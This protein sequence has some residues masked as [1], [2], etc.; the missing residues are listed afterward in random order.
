MQVCEGFV[1]TGEEMSVLDNGVSVVICCHNSAERL[2]DT[3]RHIAAQ[4]VSDGVAWEVIVVDNASTDNTKY[5]A[6]DHWAVNPIAPFQVV[7]EPIL[8][9]SHARATG[10][11]K[12][13][14]EYVSFIDD[15]NWVSSDWV[16]HVFEIVD[17]NTSVAALGGRSSVVT[18]G[19]LP[20]WFE[21]FA[22]NY[23]I[24]AQEK[25]WSRPR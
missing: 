5:V 22:G 3:L 12:P 17:A 2:P 23:A 9:V 16:Q 11:A 4:Q 24:G 19:Q 15:D 10:L 18:D 14:F 1:W 25:L 21:R 8:G 6:N 13:R 7:H 20:V